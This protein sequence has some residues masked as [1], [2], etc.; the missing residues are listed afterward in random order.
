MSAVTPTYFSFSDLTQKPLSNNI[1]GRFCQL[2]SLIPS[3]H[4]EDPRT[5]CSD[6]KGYNDKDLIMIY[7]DLSDLYDEIFTLADQNEVYLATMGAS[8]MSPSQ[9]LKFRAD[10]L[11]LKNPILIDCDSM[12]KRME[13]TY[14]LDIQIGD[15]SPLNA[16]QHWFEAARF[17]SNYLLALGLQSKLAIAHKWDEN[18]QDR[19]RVLDTIRTVYNYRIELLH[20]TSQEPMRAIFSRAQCQD[21]NIAH[22]SVT[23]SKKPNLSVDLPAYCELADKVGFYFRAHQNDLKKA[24]EKGGEQL[25]IS[26]S[27]LWQ[28]IKDTSQSK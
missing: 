8:E 24:A 1:Q 15:R 9:L 21:E 17:I 25:T 26:D 5:M 19:N 22:K 12:L 6:L 4:F 7:E 27:R 14:L 3:N 18:W 28:R 2:L 10:E 11:N 20:L 13:R 23:F 16:R